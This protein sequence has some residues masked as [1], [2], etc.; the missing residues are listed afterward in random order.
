MYQSK[1]FIDQID[2]N[3]LYILSKN[4]I[5]KLKSSHRYHTDIA[6]IRKCD[7]KYFLFFYDI[8]FTR[9]GSQIKIKTFYKTKLNI[10]IRQAVSIDAALDM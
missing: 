5:K 1:T 10:Q 9:H 7:S 6:K 3:V 8:D 2:Q 4:Y